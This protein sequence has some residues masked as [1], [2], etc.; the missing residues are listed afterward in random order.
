PLHTVLNCTRELADDFAG[1]LNRFSDKDGNNPTLSAG[2][3]IVHHT[4]P[5][6]ESLETMRRAEKEA[7]SVDG[8]NAL[9]ITL[10]KRSGSDATIKGSWRS[11][12]NTN[13]SF[14]ERLKWFVYLHLAELLPSGVA[15]ELRNLWLRFR[16]ET[17]SQGKIKSGFEKI[18]KKEAFRIIKRKKTPDGRRNVSDE[19]FDQ[20][21][22][23]IE[24]SDL[25]V[26]SLAKEIIV[27]KEFYKAYEQSDITAHEFA[28][29][30]G[31]LQKEVE[32]N[33]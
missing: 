21:K 24:G 5:L 10:S 14:D 2:I 15:H 26:E 19:I 1:K 32:G 18:V 4:E 12:S 28:K 11:D 6:Q 13:K 20:L 30:N 8:K 31:F 17:D 7:K 33:E 3:A 22:E 23:F 25:S 29:E 9:A 27:A 16:D